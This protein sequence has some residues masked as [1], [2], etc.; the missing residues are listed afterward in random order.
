M[1]ASAASAPPAAPAGTSLSSFLT[2]G[3]T[4]YLPAAILLN[5]NFG[6]YTANVV[7]L[8]FKMRM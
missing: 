4:H 7:G 2:R 1:S 6:D 3:L 5:P 8:R